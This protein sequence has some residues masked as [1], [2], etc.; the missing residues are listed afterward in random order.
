[1]YNYILLSNCILIVCEY[2]FMNIIWKIM[3]YLSNQFPFLYKNIIKSI[4]TR[5]MKKIPTLIWWEDH[6]SIPRG[7]GNEARVSND[8][9]IVSINYLR[10]FQKAEIMCIPTLVANQQLYGKLLVQ[11]YK[12]IANDGCIEMLN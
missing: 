10:P 11:F 7:G 1:M 6:E 5:R 3:R 9:A 2:T 4:G 8:L 12:S